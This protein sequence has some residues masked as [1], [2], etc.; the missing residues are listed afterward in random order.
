MIHPDFIEG[1]VGWTKAH[2]LVIETHCYISN[3]EFVSYQ[4]Q[5]LDN[6]LF[7]SYQIVGPCMMRYAFSERYT[8]MQSDYLK[9]GTVEIESAEKQIKS[10]IYFAIRSKIDCVRQFFRKNKLQTANA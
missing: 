6:K 4:N 9:K 2:C 1:H 8:S 5:L 7:L 10:C 3:N